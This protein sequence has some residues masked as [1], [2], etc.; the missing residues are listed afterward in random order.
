MLVNQTNGVVTPHS[1]DHTTSFKRNWPQ[2]SHI[3]S[4]DELCSASTSSSGCALVRLRCCSLP[5]QVQELLGL[6]LVKRLG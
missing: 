5:V 3:R 2:F 6:S 4:L 1:C